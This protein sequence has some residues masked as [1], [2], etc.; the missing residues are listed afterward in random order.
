[1]W[2]RRQSAR[3]RRRPGLGAAA[4][5]SSGSTSGPACPTCRRSR[6]RPG[7]A[8]CETRATTITDADLSYGDPRGVEALRS[9]L[10]DYLGRVRG[11]VAA[12][13]NVVITS[14]YT[15]ALA[16]RLPRARPG[17]RTADR[18]RVAGRSRV[19]HDRRPAPG[20]SRCRWR[21]TRTASG[22]SC[23]SAANADAVVV[24]PAHQHP[25]GA[26]LS[27]ARRTD[28]RRLAARAR[29]DRD[30]GRLRRRVPLRPRGRRGAARASSPTGSS[31]PARPARRWRRRS[32]SAGSSCRSA[33]RAPS[34]TRSSSTDRGHRPD[35]AA[36]VRR[37]PDVAAS[38][39]G[40]CA[41]CACATARRREALVDGAGRR[42]PRGDRPRHRRRPAPD[43]RAAAGRRRAGD[44]RGGARPPDRA[45]HDVATTASG[46]G[47]RRSCSA[48]GTCPSPRSGRASA[49]W[50]RRSAQPARNAGSAVDIRTT[51][52]MMNRGGE[53]STP[54]SRHGHGPRRDDRRGD[55]GAGRLPAERRVRARR[56]LAGRL[57]GH[58]RR[59]DAAARRARR[60][61]RGPRRPHRRGAHATRSSPRPTR[62]RRWRSGSTGRAPTS[63]PAGRGG[64]C[65]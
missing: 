30:R 26:V 2:P 31:T 54:G 55:P 20:S 25:T 51:A 41:G 18:A 52:R 39:T 3:A 14:G 34:A 61:P 6:A 29:R 63:A 5:R 45:Q 38:S 60:R 57:E 1:M 42:A 49:S 15:Q 28:A 46:P 53:A 13:E 7:R 43:R 8:A 11:V 35:R 48:T 27:S 12:T 58:A 4:R 23:S 21:S 22:S 47:R 9:A 24:T 56:R 59:P 50:R 19:R 37:L 36:R 65:A 16:R 62:P 44:P 40:T 64:P 10:A 33:A 32:G 17:G